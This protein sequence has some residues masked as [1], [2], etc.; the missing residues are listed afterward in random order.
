MRERHEKYDKLTE[1]L[2][3]KHKVLMDQRDSEMRDLQDKYN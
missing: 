2:R 3:H 1:N